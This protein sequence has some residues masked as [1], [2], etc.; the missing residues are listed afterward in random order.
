[1]IL[2]ISFGTLPYILLRKDA[3]IFIVTIKEKLKKYFN[4]EFNHHQVFRLDSNLD[5]I[6][7]NLPD[8]LW[9]FSLTSFI[10]LSTR[11]D[12]KKI[13]LLYLFTGILVMLFLEN[14]IGTFDWLDILAMFSGFIISILLLRTS[15]KK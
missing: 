6:V 15:I 4:I 7:Y 2:P 1:M 5:W 13:Q 3:A 9:A 11:T 14:T 10:L 12:S 8:A